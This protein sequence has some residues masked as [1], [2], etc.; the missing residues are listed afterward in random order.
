MIRIDL[1]Q[2]SQEWLEFRRNHI[3]STDA[4]VI[5]GISPWQ[6]PY[7]LYFQKMN[8]TETP[9][10]WAMK[11][12]RELEPIA[13][14]MFIIEKNIFIDPCVGISE[15]RSWQSASLDG[16]S[17]DGQI[18]AE[19]KCGS[20][21]LYLQACND[22]IPIY[23]RV[24]IQ[25]QLCVSKAVKCYYVAF[26]NNRIKVI[27]VFPDW[28]FIENMIQKQENFLNLL[29]KMEPPP[30]TDED[31][32]SIESERGSQ[33]LREYHSLGLQEKQIKDKRDELKQ[34]IIQINP[35]RNF[36]LDGFKVYQKSN[37]SYNT[38]K[39]AL[40]GINIEAYRSTSKPFWTIS[41]P[42][43]IKAD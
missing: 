29:H 35:Q 28:E 34:Q 1:E 20:E 16:I 31:Y 39:M 21:D 40:D 19:I 37:V 18:I 2:G 11:K 6:T 22:E 32:T 14:Q 36:I 9:D 8:G 13:R 33:M 38:K 25:H 24:Q 43:R 5:E 42:G 23:Y 12:G 10:N 7:E 3:G 41:S 17:E 27:E 15:E 4:Y 30:M 26:Y